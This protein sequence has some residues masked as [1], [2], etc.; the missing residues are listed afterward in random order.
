MIRW[1]RR[2]RV[3]IARGGVRIPDVL[4]MESALPPHSSVFQP[5][6]GS[7]ARARRFQHPS[8]CL[9]FLGVTGSA[10]TLSSAPLPSL[11][12]E[13]SWKETQEKAGRHTVSWTQGQV[14][15]PIQHLY[16][17]YLMKLRGK[18]N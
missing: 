16:K 8:A 11:P 12:P 15:F 1:G 6:E 17:S 9:A 4:N 5:Q 10:F 3:N 18:K 2:M 14:T 7:T 13:H